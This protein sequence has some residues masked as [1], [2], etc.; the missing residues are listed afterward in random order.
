MTRSCS[1]RA[2]AARAF[3]NYFDSRYDLVLRLVQGIEAEMMEASRLWF[4]DASDDP[5]ATLKSALDAAIAVWVRHGHVLHALHQASYHDAEVERYYRGGLVEP[6]IDAVAQRLRAE[7]RAGRTSIPSPNDMAHALITLNINVLSERLGRVAG[8]APEHGRQNAPARLA[9]FHLRTGADGDPAC[10][11]PY[12]PLHGACRGRAAVSRAE[13][14]DGRNA[15]PDDAVARAILAAARQEFI[16]FGLRRANVEEIARRSDVSRI[17]VY[18][19]F[20]SKTQLLRAVVMEDLLGALA[21]F[22]GA[23]FAEGAFGARVEEA[24]LLMVRRLRGDALLSTVLRSDPGPAL[25]SLTIDGRVAFDFLRDLVAARIGEL[26]SR[27]EI[28]PVD[29]QRTAEILVRLGYSFVLFP[30]GVLPGSTE[31]A[32]RAFARDHVVPLMTH[33]LK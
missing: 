15:P 18:R 31:Q 33:P 8:R 16:R 6:F 2:C 22:D 4:D 32:I 27:G 7:K 14:L 23:L 1:A 11:D 21:E 28:P 13:G 3:Y 30:Y 9:P 20:A 29:A 25:R 17:T 19:R 26:E 5:V 24:V 10:G 12:D